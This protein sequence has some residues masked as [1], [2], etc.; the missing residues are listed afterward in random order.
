MTATLPPVSNKMRDSKR[1]AI[2]NILASRKLSREE[3][4][5]AMR[6]HLAQHAPVKNKEVTII[7]TI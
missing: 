1:G 4:V 7:S 5:L 6:Q 2:Y 3:M